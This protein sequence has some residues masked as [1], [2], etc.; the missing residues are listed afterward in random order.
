[1]ITLTLLKRN[2]RPA[3]F[4]CSGHANRGEYGNDLVC[5]AVSAITQTCVIGLIDILG[6][7]AE[8]SADEAS[9]LDC[10]LPSDM[11]EP[12]R[13][14]AALLLETMLAGLR[15]VEASYPGTLKTIDR[16]V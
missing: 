10:R 3:G 14:R 6:L 2:G 13:E 12:Q 16:E 11:D 5:S 15:A 1:M 4:R 9:G 8:V 7:R